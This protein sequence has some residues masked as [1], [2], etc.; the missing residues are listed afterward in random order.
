MSLEP[1]RE[2]QLVELCFAMWEEALVRSGV[3]ASSRARRIELE[4]QTTPPMLWSF[5]P[6]RRDRLFLPIPTRDAPLV[7]RLAP[8][9]LADLF[10]P[11]SDSTFESVSA[12]GDLDVLAVLRDLLSSGN[13]AIEL[14]AG[15]SSESIE[16]GPVAP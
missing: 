5:D 13:D 2:R 7:L 10:R 12:C 14:R 3:R 16:E 4:V 6:A 1:E 9:D 11:N 15:R 8:K